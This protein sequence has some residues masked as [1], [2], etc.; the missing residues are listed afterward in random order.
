MVAQLY[1]YKYTQCGFTTASVSVPISISIPIPILIFCY[2]M[3]GSNLLWYVSWFEPLCL[4]V[5]LGSSL[6]I[7]YT[8]Y[9]RRVS[10]LLSSYV[11]I[12]II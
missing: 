11:V 3:G 1:N 12:I 6:G 10:R 8:R 7:L 9:R 2:R 5:Q 4:L